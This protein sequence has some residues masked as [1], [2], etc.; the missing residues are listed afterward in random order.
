MKFKR[1]VTA[2]RRK[3]DKAVGSERSALR[4]ATVPATAKHVLL[5]VPN[6]KSP[7]PV[8]T[9]T[10][11]PNPFARLAEGYW[12]ESRLPLAGLVFIT[13]L[14]ITYEMGVQVF[15][16]QNGA[17]AWMRKL[18]DLMG[19]SQHFLL[20]ILIV[21]ILLGWHYLT[22]RPWR[23][24]R[25]LLWGMAGEC[26]LLALCLRMLYQLQSVVLAGAV[27]PGVMSVGE[28]IGTAIGYLGAGIYEE[29]LF[30]LIL[31]SVVAWGLRRAGMTPRKSTII[32][33][34]LTSLVFS[35]AHYVGS[36]GDS[37]EWFGFVFRFLAGV[38]FSILFIC[39]GFGIA[40][41][42]HAGYDILVGV[43]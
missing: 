38:F 33:V 32:A 31:L 25:G 34:L 42:M 7:I 22:R 28:T 2:S 36:H 4:K 30:R 27:E 5:H 16:V 9:E 14:L 39:R 10:P 17:D 41:G 3:G 1:G 15:G 40:A 29:L 11:R 24:S 20:P 35:A 12:A 6:L 18:L 43:L 13:P 21:C 8:T 19:F 23:I 37:L 26:I